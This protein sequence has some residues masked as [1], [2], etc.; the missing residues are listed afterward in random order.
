MHLVFRAIC[1][2][3]NSNAERP[4]YKDNVKNS[5]CSLSYNFVGATETKILKKVNMENNSKT[6]VNEHLA[7][8]KT[9]LH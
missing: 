6:L 5:T 4:N 2:D 8:T 3:E 1:H 7:L 9:M